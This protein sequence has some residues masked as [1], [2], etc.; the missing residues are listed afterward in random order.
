MFFGHELSSAALAFIRL[1]IEFAVFET[2]IAGVAICACVAVPG[3]GFA[4]GAGGVGAW[5]AG[6]GEAFAFYYLV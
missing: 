2:A 4:E 6:W 1:F 3:A 5:G